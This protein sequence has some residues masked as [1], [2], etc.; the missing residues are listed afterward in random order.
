MDTAGIEYTF[1]LEYITINFLGQTNKLCF[2]Y[3]STLNYASEIP[4][5]LSHQNMISSHIKITCDLHIGKVH[6]CYGNIINFTLCT[7]SF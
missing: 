3:K 7:N 6:C 4:G 2:Q 5:E 1:L